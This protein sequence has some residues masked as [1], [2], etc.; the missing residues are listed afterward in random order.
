DADLGLLRT[1]FTARPV[2]ARATGSGFETARRD[3][4]ALFVVVDRSTVGLAFRE[5]T[6]TV[7]ARPEVVA[8]LRGAPAARTGVLAR[9][10]ACSAARPVVRTAPRLFAVVLE[11]TCRTPLAMNG[12]RSRR[13]WG[14]AP[15]FP[16]TIPEKKNRDAAVKRN[17]IWYQDLRRFAIS[18]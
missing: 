12:A 11:V 13:I 5:A 1:V 4:D 10:A 18:N 15:G 16:A 17:R 7:D 8:L 2:V 6:G 14:R 3:G 9:L